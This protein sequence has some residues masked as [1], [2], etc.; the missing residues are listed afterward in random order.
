MERP[1]SLTFWRLL[2]AFTGLLTLPVLFQI[3]SLADELGFSLAQPRWSALV[4]FISLIGIG[5]FLLL[6]LSWSRFQS[7]LPEGDALEK[8]TKLPKIVA[9]GL[10]LLSLPVF[11]GVVLHPSTGFLIGGQAWLRFL[12]FWLLSLASTFAIRNLGKQVDWSLSLVIA[13]L[14]QAVFF[15]IAASLS[16]VSN[17]PFLPGWSE[18]S[19]Y[20]DASLLFARRI[21][22]MKVPLAALHPSLHFL[23]AVP[24]I[25]PDLPLWVHRLWQAV[26]FLGLNA[27]TAL[28]LA[29]RLSI[30]SRYIN[31]LFTAWCFLFLLQGPVYI[32][33]LVPVLIILI[34]ASPK[35]HWGTLLAVILASVWAGI[36]RINWFPVPGLLAAVLY[37]VEVPVGRGS[38]R[39]LAYLWKPASWLLVGTATSFI[40][41]YLFILLSG[42]A[43]RQAFFSSLT[44]DLLWYRLLPNATYPPGILLGSLLVLL[45]ILLLLFWM[46]RGRLRSI[47]PIRWL[48]ISAAVGLLFAGGLVVSVK[49]GGGADLHNMDAFLILLLILGGYGLLGRVAPDEPEANNTSL[50]KKIP[51]YLA[52]FALLVPLWFA[53]QSGEPVIRQDMARASQVLQ[54]IQTRSMEI[55]QNGGEVLFISQRH[56]LAFHLVKGIP[57]VPDYEKDFLVEMVMSHNKPYLG[58]FYQDLRQ[59]RFGLIVVDPQTTALLGSRY[60]FGEENNAWVL[61]VAIP[62]LCAY[63]PLET[64]PEVRLQL[65]VPCPDCKSCP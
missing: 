43:D 64:F 44:S 25:F 49:I 63:T 15:T 46:M 22:A 40:S 41:Q 27:G 57:L 2:L 6:L 16:Q 24:F 54:Q 38:K 52:G 9:I 31:W 17:Y 36:S 53:V 39:P 18:S 42:N 58:R 29:R 60:R 51:W 56:L 4:A 48:G 35:N 11:S 14:L 59:G 21:Y 8:I 5:A 10:L 12:A 65:L 45:P 28:C 61:K 33:L 7:M 3:R 62:L 20:Y 32:H 50:N 13:L 1:T 23:L 19:R 26:L 47:H 34:F 30:P 37:L 55:V